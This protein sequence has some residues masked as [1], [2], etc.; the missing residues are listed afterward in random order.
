MVEVEVINALVERQLLHPYF[1]VMW[2]CRSM[3]IYNFMKH[4]YYTKKLNKLFSKLYLKM[5]KNT[6]INNCAT[7]ID[8]LYPLNNMG[9]FEDFYKNFSGDK[10]IIINEFPN[11]QKLKFI[12]DNQNKI[13][14]LGFN[15][16][17]ED[18]INYKKILKNY[19]SFNVEYIHNKNIR[20]KMKPTI[21]STM[22]TKNLRNFIY[23]NVVDLDMKNSQVNIFIN[24]IKIFSLGDYP[25][26]NK[27]HQD[28]NKFLE[29][30]NI[31]KDNLITLLNG[32]CHNT[33]DECQGLSNE[34]QLLYNKFITM[35]IFKDL[36]KGC[37]NYIYYSNI[38]GQNKNLRT[39][40]IS[41]VYQ[42]IEVKILLL[43]Y[44]FL[45]SK[46]YGV[47]SLEYDGL[48]IKN[49][50]NDCDELNNF[51]K[52]KSGLEVEFL[53]KP[54]TIDENLKI[55]YNE[56]VP[57]ELNELVFDN[58]KFLITYNDLEDGFV[59]V[60]E[61]LLPKLIDNLKY[62]C[63][64]WYGVKNN[65]WVELNP[66]NIIS[67]LLHKGFNTYKENVFNYLKE[68]EELL[69]K[70]Q[71]KEYLQKIK[72]GST[73]IESSSFLKHLTES[74]TEFLKDD[75]FK[76]KLDK[77]SYC[78]TFTNG[79]YDIKNK[80]FRK[81]ILSTDYLSK[82]LNFEY[83]ENINEEKK[84]HIL[85]ELFKICNCDKEQLEYVLTL[86]GY[87]LCGDPS[88]HQIFTFMLGGG[89]NGK[90]FI[91]NLLHKIM[92]CYVDDCNSNVLEENFEK[93]HKFFPKFAMNRIIY[94][95]ELKKN[96]KINSGL[97]K[98]LADGK[99][100]NFEVL[101]KTEMTID[102]MAKPVLVANPP[103]RFDDL[104]KGTQRRY[105]HLQHN[106]QFL[107]EFT[108]DD[109]ENKNFI[110]DESISND[111]INIYYREFVS[112]IIDYMII[113]N[114]SG[115]PDKPQLFKNETNEIKELN[116]EFGTFFNE[117]F[118]KTKNKDDKISKSY[119]K[120]L[121]QE[122]FNKKITDSDIRECMKQLNNIYDKG[123]RI[124]KDRGG[125]RYLKLNDDDDKNNS[126][127]SSSS[128]SDNY[129]D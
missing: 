44:E 66:I 106:S 76:F 15:K 107:P 91:L 82:T 12:L 11:R 6:D 80:S 52:E 119:V 92:G 73:K 31:T 118:I 114:E 14:E 21:N 117:N 55:I 29:D 65:L 121:Y 120:E 94:F 22:M 28:K 20:M 71:K 88:K 124:N 126:D 75:L 125:W 25:I 93:Q 104:D 33:T 18:C 2:R 35:N 110:A 54:M 89:G 85:H 84:E 70:F 63:K 95:N 16:V 9:M 49:N 113:Y 59:N 32:G 79:I 38:N 4:K 86:F 58:D 48:K 98:L 109:Y 46:N 102:M 43:T 81:G 39:S 41:W 34:I 57:K 96:K 60:A 45:K 123:L 77:N 83:K 40:Y 100:L 61:K 23:D 74:L 72:S 13:K 7:K 47:G 26:L 5:D 108:E 64:E 115:F 78:L 116:D 17:I 69:D 19:S 37:K 68:N 42:S 105:E 36:Y 122:V 128:D 62:C 27:V 10:K 111:I 67:K 112:I 101:F 99:S 53:I 3:W 87:M 30:N 56:F 51:I 50:F 129:S 103:L 90:T 97:V 8:F 1:S 127:S 24:L